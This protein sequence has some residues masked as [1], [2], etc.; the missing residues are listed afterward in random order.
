MYRNSCWSNF[1]T[2]IPLVLYEYNA[3]GIYSI[4]HHVCVPPVYYPI[5]TIG[6]GGTADSRSRLSQAIFQPTPIMFG[7]GQSNRP[8]QRPFS[9]RLSRSRGRHSTG[10]FSFFF[11][12]SSLSLFLFLTHCCN[13]CASSHGLVIAGHLPPPHYSYPPSFLLD[14]VVVCVCVCVK[15]VPR[16][17]PSSLPIAVAARIEPSTQRTKLDQSNHHHHLPRQILSLPRLPISSSFGRD[18][19][20]GYSLYP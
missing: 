16:C 18:S 19:S 7:L 9:G 4:T 10:A 1:L 3:I 6:I 12:P 8:N 5:R 17:P 20:F 2:C 15:K 14:C 13:P 11:F